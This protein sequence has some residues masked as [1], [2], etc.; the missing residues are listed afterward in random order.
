MF[1]VVIAVAVAVVVGVVVVVDVV[2]VVIREGGT[3]VCN[4]IPCVCFIDNY[5]G[6]FV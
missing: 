5:S 6:L 4:S 3:S 2:D 1:V